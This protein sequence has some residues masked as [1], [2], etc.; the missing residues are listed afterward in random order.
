MTNFSFYKRE[1][2]FVKA[3]HF[4]FI[5]KYIFNKSSIDAVSLIMILQETLTNFNH[6]RVLIL[7]YQDFIHRNLYIFVKTN[8]Y[9]A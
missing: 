2:N 4:R 1:E 5:I 7:F 8:L 3:V 9:H 6:T